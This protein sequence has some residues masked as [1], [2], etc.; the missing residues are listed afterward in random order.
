MIGLY[1]LETFL[2]QLVGAVGWENGFLSCFCHSSSPFYFCRLNFVVTGSFYRLRIILSLRFS[3]LRFDTFL[4]R[5]GCLSSFVG[6]HHVF[7][8][9]LLE[10]ISIGWMRL[11]SFVGRNCHFTSDQGKKSH[12]MLVDI[13]KNGIHFSRSL[14]IACMCH[15]WRSNVITAWYLIKWPPPNYPVSLIGSMESLF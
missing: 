9:F 10:W 11:K 1:C 13:K 4:Y 7:P 14:I 15:P 2:Q 8:F 5:F 3:L 12:D 6:C